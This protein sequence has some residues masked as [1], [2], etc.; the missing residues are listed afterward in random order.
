M[1]EYIS[2]EAAIEAIRN[3][4]GYF[5]DNGS[6]DHMILKMEAE[7]AISDVDEGIVRC[8]DCKHSR[9]LDRTDP[10]EDSFIDGCVWCMLGRG[11]GLLPTQFCDN[12][13]PK[14]GAGNG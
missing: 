4:D 6:T 14:E 2:R 1:A 3:Y 9:E 11:D 10:Y 13:E 7:I 12:G 5:Q 8:G